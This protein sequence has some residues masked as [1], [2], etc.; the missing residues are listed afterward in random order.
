VFTYSDANWP[1]GEWLP[2]EP[3]LAVGEGIW[4]RTTAVGAWTRDFTV[5]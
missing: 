2:S 1:D 5:K 3:I 4:I